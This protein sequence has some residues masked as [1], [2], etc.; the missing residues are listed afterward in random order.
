[1]KKPLFFINLLQQSMLKR[2]RAENA[3]KKNQEHIAGWHSEAVNGMSTLASFM[4][5]TYAVSYTHLR[6]HET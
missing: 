1:M 2:L 3:R 5:C 6:A 4:F